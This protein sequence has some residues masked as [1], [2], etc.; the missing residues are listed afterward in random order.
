MR[1]FASDFTVYRLKIFR[2]KMSKKQRFL[3]HFSC[4]EKGELIRLSHII[5][6]MISAKNF[7]NRLGDARTLAKLLNGVNL[8]L[9][10]HLD[11]LFC[12][13]VTKTWEGVE[14]HTDFSVFGEEEFR[15]RILQ[16][17]I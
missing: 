12:G 10:A 15:I 1:A 8:A 7:N 16:G 3:A 6:N 4:L 14:G 5:E 2:Y 11:N 17:D 9:V 13:G